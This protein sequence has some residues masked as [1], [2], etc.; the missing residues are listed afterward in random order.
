MTIEE[1]KIILDEN[2]KKL[3]ELN[4]KLSILESSAFSF[5]KFK[6]ISSVKKELSQLRLAIRRDRD[7]VTLL[8]QDNG[9]KY[10]Q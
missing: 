9:Y 10:E 3:T 1:L 8:E 6:E 7:Y 4:K 2:R 5:F